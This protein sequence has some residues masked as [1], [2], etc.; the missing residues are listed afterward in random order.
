MDSTAT[1]R[2]SKKAAGLAAFFGAVALATS[3]LAQA[4]EEQTAE[5]RIQELERRIEILAEE[6][7]GAR[8][9]SLVVEQEYDTQ[10]GVGPA[11]GKIYQAA[12]GGVTI[13]GY[14][15]AFY[16]NSDDEGKD[17]A[18]FLRN[19]LY[20]GYRFSDRI[21]FNSEIE[22]EHADEIYL[23]FAYLDFLFNEQFNVRAGMMLTPLGFVN[24]V[25]E[26]QFFFGNLRPPVETQIIPSTTRENGAGIYGRLGGQLDYRLYIQNS[27]N[28]EG[29]SDSN[30]RGLR[31]KG[32]NAKAGDL[33]VTGR[34]DWRPV[35]GVT[36]G[37]SFWSG[38]MAHDD[39]FNGE[40]IDLPMNLFDVRAQY[41]YGG[42]KLRALYTRAEID[43]TLEVSLD[44]GKAIG[45]E[46]EGWYAEVGY[47]I[48]TLWENS[49][50]RQSLYPWVRY[51]EIDTQA[52]IDQDVI[53]AGFSKNPKNER[54]VTEIGLHY[55]PH[56]NVVIKGELREFDSEDKTEADGTNNQSEFVLGIGYNF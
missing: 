36:L 44:K 17:E 34:L 10:L 53:T 12:E 3:P 21:L 24:E 37:T 11:G 15:E 20:F 14:G 47:D 39:T 49:P 54:T 5:Q 31:Q 40:D 42:L 56:P 6:I 9:E 18:D 26:P 1:S 19:V 13:G 50:D 25:H 52:S 7:E 33:A 48:F 22:I 27:F 45:E 46:M 28:G 29:I 30:L 23:E 35:A 43:D 51:S 8:R 41:N 4:A 32:S 2:G 55:L 16:L 38:N